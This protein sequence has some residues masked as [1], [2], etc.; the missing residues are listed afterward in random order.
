[1]N[2]RYCDLDAE[3]QAMMPWRTFKDCPIASPMC[4]LG[5]PYLPEPGLF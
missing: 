1:M 4:F 2:L 5:E 3:E